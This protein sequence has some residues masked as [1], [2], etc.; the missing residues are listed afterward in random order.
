MRHR[1]YHFFNVGSIEDCCDSPTVT[2]VANLS[3]FYTIGFKRL[4]YKAVEEIDLKESLLFTLL[5]KSLTI[6]SSSHN[7]KMNPRMVPGKLF[8]K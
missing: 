8:Q 5:N 3:A 7:T 6:T 1:T 4:F 2:M